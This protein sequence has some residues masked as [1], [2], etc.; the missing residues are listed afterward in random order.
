MHKLAEICVRRPVFATMLVLALTVMGGFAFFGLGVDRLPNAD[1]PVV[2]VSVANPGAS[3][4]EIERDITDKIEGA[5]NTV[6]GINELTSQSVEGMSIVTVT[7]RLEKNGDV[8]AQE[9]RQKVDLALEE[10]PATARPPVVQK[11]DLGAEPVLLYALTAERPLVE[12]T[13]IAQRG[14]QE[15]LQSVSG[16]GNITLYGGRK[17]EI[18]ISLRPERLRAYGLTAVDVTSALRAQSV[19]LPAGS[20]QGALE[21]TALRTAGKIQEVSGFPEIVVATREGFPVRVRDVAEV[22]DHGAPPVSIAAQDDA[23][24]VVLSVQ[25]QAGGNSV[26]VINAVKERL[27]EIAPDLP[28]DVKLHLVQDQSE[29]I[30]NAL[31]AIEE[32]LVMG[33]ILASVVVYLFLRNFRSTIIAALAIPIS[34]IAAFGVMYAMGYTLNMMTML[35]LTLMVGIVID[36]AIIVL[37]NI[38][39]FVE[40]KGMAPMEAALHGTKEIGL[41]V[42]ATTLS[43]LAVFVPI[44]FMQGVVG[45]FLSSF[46]LT[47]AAAI[48]VSLL[49]SFTL[50]PMLAARWIRP[51]DGGGHQSKES[52]FYG[53]IDRGYTRLL[54]WS[55]AHRGAVVAICAAVVLSIIP[56]GV[57]TGVTFTP[58]EDEN[59]FRVTVRMKPG[60]GLANAQSVLEQM[61]RDLRGGLRG[62]ESTLAIA[63]FNEEQEPHSGSIF[64]R[65]QAKRDVGTGELMADARKLL[66]KYPPEI[67]TAVQSSIQAGGGSRET[68]IAY[69]IAGPDLKKLDEYSRQVYDAMKAS[70]EM[71][72]VD[73]SFSAGRPEIRLEVDKARAADSNVRVADIAATIN[74]LYA[75]ERAGSF[76]VG[77]RQYGV[78]ARA[79]RDSRENSE[80]LAELTVPAVDGSPVNLASLVKFARGIGVSNIDR[81]NRERQVTLY[82]NLP[83]GGAESRALAVIEQAVRKLQLPDGYRPVL[84]GNTKLLN[85]ATGAFVTAVVLSFVFMYMVLAAQFESFLHPVTILLTLPLSIPFG[86]L[87]SWLAGQQLNIFSALGILLLFGVVKKNAILQIDHT[88]ELR[89]QGMVRHEA[90]ILANRQRLRPILMT[91]IALVAGMVPLVVSGGPGSATNRSI[92]VLVI[93]GQSLCLLLTLLAVPVFYSLFEDLG[94]HPIWRR[95]WERRRLVWRPAAI[96][97][98]VAAGA[99]AQDYPRNE[100]QAVYMYGQVDGRLGQGDSALAGKFQQRRPHHGFALS[101]VSNGSRISGLKVEVSWMRDEQRVRTPLGQFTYRQEPLWLLAGSQFKNNRPDARFKPFVHLLGGAARFQ[102]S[103]SGGGAAGCAAAF[104]SRECPA[105]FDG[106][107]WS[108]VTVIGGGLDV[109]L[110]SRVDLRLAQIDY[111]PLRRFGKTAHNVRFGVGFVFH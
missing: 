18:Q 81:I 40:E 90:I 110:S 7:F 26:A 104:G 107:R 42:M 30:Q 14:I 75:G 65:L 88:R 63:G 99:S 98:F 57:L 35:A 51:T 31:H 27:A 38:Y 59:S 8:A 45:R 111:T 103:I 28:A 102:T 34:T 101:Y 12:L 73:R 97:L 50:T 78:V 84:T 66:R 37:E 87:S 58:P 95:L 86:L 15:K 11:I 9:V 56:L 91:T 60:T 53:A 20:V 25:K 72:D 108:F 33:G 46:G 74:T 1:F 49:V 13:E 36:D 10:L 17:R 23:T 2:T 85:E 32:H 96:L 92:G 44:G 80:S 68:A 3:P 100:V 105:R 54:Q 39:R 21:R 52:A 61:A 83:P 41:A 70:P 62:V 109:R 93:G 77:T 55:M 24:A 67:Y 48:A 47:A 69:V 71:V 6:S 79:D 94:A 5:V 29:F 16:V 4:E 106:D 82:A 43:L 64:V 89:A 76:N 19:E 22:E